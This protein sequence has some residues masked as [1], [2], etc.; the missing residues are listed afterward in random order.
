M[1]EQKIDERYKSI[2]SR[3]IY[4]TSCKNFS[5][6]N[7]PCFIC[8]EYVCNRDEIHWK[9]VSPDEKTIT[10]CTHTHTHIHIHTARMFNSYA[11]LENTG[12]RDSCDGPRTLIFLINTQ[13][14]IFIF[15]LVYSFLRFLCRHQSDY[16]SHEIV[17][18]EFLHNYFSFP[19]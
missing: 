12:K 7:Y 17:K 8:D 15:P 19:Q 14:A 11:F 16:Y 6:R 18:L 4:W 2:S 5:L 1:L 3:I 13:V 10:T 9:T